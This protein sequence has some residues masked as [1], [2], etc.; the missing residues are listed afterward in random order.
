M[1]AHTELKSQAWVQLILS[2][3]RVL[4]PF[5]L[6]QLLLLLLLRARA[7]STIILTVGAEVVPLERLGQVERQQEGEQVEAPERQVGCRE[8]PAGHHPPRRHGRPAHELAALLHLLP[9]PLGRREHPAR[10]VHHGHRR[11]DGERERARPRRGQALGEH[12][13][14]EEERVR[15]GRA[16]PGRVPGPEPVEDVERRERG[17]DDEPHRGVHGEAEAAGEAREHGCGRVGLARALRE[18]DAGEDEEVGEEQHRERDLRERDRG[19]E[20][21]HGGGAQR[22]ELL[23]GEEV[24]VVVRTRRRGRG[25]RVQR[26]RWRAHGRQRDAAPRRRADAA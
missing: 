13:R 16:D 24:V 2:N 22:V 25:R 6:L 23:D 21:Q 8:R 7:V 5:T 19:G 12:L 1:K 11:P 10:A 17:A 15:G 9:Q 14:G 18:G 26:R 3:L 20:G 4:L